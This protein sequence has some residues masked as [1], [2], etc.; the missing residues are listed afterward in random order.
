MLSHITNY[1]TY[2]LYIHEYTAVHNFLP[3]DQLN[4]HLKK[5]QHSNLDYDHRL[6][7]GFRDAQNKLTKIF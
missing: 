5:S 3:N 2:I 1:F 7:V 6:I 4:Q